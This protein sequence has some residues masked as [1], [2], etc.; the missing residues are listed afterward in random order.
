MSN[1]IPI[2]ANQVEE[3]RALRRDCHWCAVMGV[4]W[5]RKHSGKADLQSYPADG[6]MQLREEEEASFQAEDDAPVQVEDESSAEAATEPPVVKKK[7]SKSGKVNNRK[8]CHLCG[9]GEDGHGKEYNMSNIAD[10]L[11]V[12]WLEDNGVQAHR[13]C[14]C[15]KEDPTKCLVSP[16]PK[17][18]NTYRCL[19]CL[20]GHKKCSFK[21][22]F[23]EG[24]RCKGGLHPALKGGIGA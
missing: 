3:K 16:F 20:R 6:D 5:C 14:T 13:P 9:V 24:R 2:N 19:S 4:D 17:N 21:D 22:E 7:V 10:H 18:K 1:F 23:E 11:K 15:C 8:T 12:H